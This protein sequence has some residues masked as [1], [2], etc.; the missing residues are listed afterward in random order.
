MRKDIALIIL[1]ALAAAGCLTPVQKLGCCLK[2]NAT[3]SPAVCEFYNT[4][5]YLDQGPLPTISCD[6]LTG[7]NV[8]IGGGDRVLPI[9]TGDQIVSCIAP[10]C[11]ALVCG[12][13]AYKPRVAPG[14]TS[15]DQAQGNAPPDLNN[16]GAALQFYKAQCRFLPLDSKLRQ[17]MKNSKSQ[18]DVFRIGAGG[19]FDEF[20][21]YRYFFP[22]S[23]KYSRS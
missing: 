8:T 10:D 9:C 20:D 3:Q 6:N 5:S 4:S 22:I 16:E 11:T 7:C 15:I 12:D 19:S 1:I 13:Y 17:I 14:F 2:V 18:I 23:D 21:Q